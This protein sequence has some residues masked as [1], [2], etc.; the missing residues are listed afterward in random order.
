MLYVTLGMGHNNKLILV[1]VVGAFV[2]VCLTVLAH[3]RGR[4]VGRYELASEVLLYSVL[5]NV[6]PDNEGA[7]DLRGAQRVMLLEELSREPPFGYSIGREA[8]PAALFS[9]KIDYIIEDSRGII[10]GID[11]MAMNFP[12]LFDDAK[13][14]GRLRQVYKVS[15]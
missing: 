4:E 1:L 2:T 5:E 13:A 7:Q 8:T 9:S 6:A 15:D 14:K 10:D 3:M 11:G 12:W